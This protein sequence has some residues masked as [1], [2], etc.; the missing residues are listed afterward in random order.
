MASK[1]ENELC[2]IHNSLVHSVSMDIS[3]LLGLSYLV[4][5]NHDKKLGSEIYTQL[6]QA[7][8]KLKNA[9]AKFDEI[10][11]EVIKENGSDGFIKEVNTILNDCI[12]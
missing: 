3:K 11:K 5:S 1:R 7:F 2:N 8:E 10:A 12:N 6:V 9:E 4:Y